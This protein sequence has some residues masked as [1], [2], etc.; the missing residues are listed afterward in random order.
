M[1]RVLRAVR[2]VALVA[3]PALI[4]PACGSELV[5]TAGPAPAP[6]HGPL[7]VPP[8][9]A[10]DL[11]VDPGAAGR[12]T[13]CDF[14]EVGG[15][16]TT[17]FTGGEV[18]RTAEDALQQSHDE[19]TWD[20]PIDLMQV[21]REEPDRILYAYAAAGRTKQAVIVHHGPAAKGTGAGKDGLAWWPESWSRCDVAEYPAAVTDDLGYEFWSEVGG[22]RRPIAEIVSH[23]GGDCVAGTHFLEL[24]R[25]DEDR[26]RVYV[27]HGEDPDFFAE[28][29]QADVALPADAVDTGYDHGEDHLWL[30][31]D[32]SRAYVGG[33][34]RVELWP[35]TTQPLGCG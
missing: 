28:P 3:L 22:R 8:D 5:T 25:A 12:V 19:G 2:V 10:L 1:S 13:D 35:R 14:P 24:D 16:S 7:W 6:Y 21:V 18:G 20:A 29:Y 34:D 4:A 32:Q 30:S 26:R 31:P 9:P 17:P 23:P 27:A 11:W 15:T 33:P